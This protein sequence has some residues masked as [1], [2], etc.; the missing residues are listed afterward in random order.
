MLQCIR[1]FTKLQLNCYLPLVVKN[2]ADIFYICMLMMAHGPV[3]VRATMHGIILNT[4]QS[5]ASLPQVM[6]NG[7]YIYSHQWE[8]YRMDYMDITCPPSLPSSPF[9]SGVWYCTY[10]R[11][12]IVRVV[13]EKV[14]H[15]KLFYAEEALKEVSLKLVEFSDP[16]FYMQFGTYVGY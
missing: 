5:L 10:V 8:L 14:S 2:L 12:C 7:M 3:F 11:N 15:L 1:R 4:V 16:K 9:C 6:A 13:A